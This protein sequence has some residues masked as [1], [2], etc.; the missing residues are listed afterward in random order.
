MMKEFVYK[1]GDYTLYCEVEQN[2]ERHVVIAMH[3][4]NGSMLVIPAYMEAD[5]ESLPVTAIGKKALLAATDLRQVTLPFTMRLLDDW[6]FAQCENLLQIIVQQPENQTPDAS[7]W[8]ENG[9]DIHIEFGKG[10]FDDCIH[11]DDI[12]IGTGKRD[13]LS[14]LL[15]AIPYRLQAEYLLRDNDIGSRHW[16]AKWDNSLS[17]LLD[18]DD[19]EGYTNMVLCGEEDIQRSMPDYIADKRR[20]KSG[21]CLLRLLHDDR[22][23]SYYRKK[24]QDY[25]VKHCK[26][27]KTEEAWEVILSDFGDRLEYYNIL[28]D[29]GCITEDNIDAMLLDMG[30]QHAEAKAYLIDYRHRSLG[31]GDIFSSFEL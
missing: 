2:P 19:E 22:L 11:L 15:G 6:A 7:T 30:E 5:G 28:A 14:A 1:T 21:L 9:Y 13:T 27:Q 24:Y 23:E 25:I 12:C 17:A 20:R 16:F 10:V 8:M 3:Q 29:L 26:G 4:G 31:G 18:E